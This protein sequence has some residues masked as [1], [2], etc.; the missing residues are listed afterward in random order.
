MFECRYCAR[1]FVF[2][3][4]LLYFFFFR[5]S[6]NHVVEKVIQVYGLFYQAVMNFKGGYLM[7]KEMQM[8]CASIANTTVVC[9]LSCVKK[10]FLIFCV[11][12]FVWLMRRHE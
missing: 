7:R 9:L 4:I 12:F 5:K 2:G 3:F 1:I 8:V 11:A 10:L 6:P